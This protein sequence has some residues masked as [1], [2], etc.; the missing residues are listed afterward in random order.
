[1]EVSA[2]QGLPLVAFD[3]CKLG[4]NLFL[5]YRECWLYDVSVLERFQSTI[6]QLISLQITG[7][8][9]TFFMELRFSSL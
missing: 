7:I 1:M 9:A 3:Y 8:P 2:L 6:L 5:L 4:Q